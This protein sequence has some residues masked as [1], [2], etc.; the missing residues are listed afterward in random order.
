MLLQLT[1]QLPWLLYLCAA[2]H[3]NFIFK[4]HYHR[5]F[6]LEMILSKGLEELNL[7]SQFLAVQN[8]RVLD[9]IY[10]QSEYVLKQSCIEL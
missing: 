4:Y 3:G 8:I 9:F 2:Y 10:F 5:T 6:V 7:H 1:P